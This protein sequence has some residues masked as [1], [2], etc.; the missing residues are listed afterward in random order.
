MLERGEKAPA[1]LHTAGSIQALGVVI[2]S[3][4]I[5]LLQGIRFFS[6]LDITHNSRVCGQLV[7]DLHREATTAA[8][9]ENN[10][11]PFGLAKEALE[12]VLRT[13]PQRLNPVTWQ[14]L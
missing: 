3:L 11:G 14:P 12:E 5:S 6:Q 2:R 13:G 4:I 9:R 8:R 1:V 10:R 7:Q